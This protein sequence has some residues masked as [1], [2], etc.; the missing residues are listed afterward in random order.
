[1][2]RLGKPITL[3]VGTFIVFTVIGGLALLMGT[4]NA[5]PGCTGPAVHRCDYIETAKAATIAANRGPFQ[6]SRG[7]EVFDLG[8]SIRVQQYYPR[9]G[10]I[11]SP[12]VLIDKRSCRVCEIGTYLDPT[13]ETRGQLTV[14]TVAEDPDGAAELD[15]ELALEG[16]PFWSDI[17]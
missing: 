15:R 16:A 5:S 14:R 12:S 1:M 4:N 3:G 8:S 17:L 6:R 10:L 13:D 2:L 11:E 9:M 7:F